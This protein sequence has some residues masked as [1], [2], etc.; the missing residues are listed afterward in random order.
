MY[1][2]RNMFFVL[3]HMHY[4]CSYSVAIMRKG[5]LSLRKSYS[6]WHLMDHSMLI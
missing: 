1:R 2:L 4:M 5:I 6:L 3:Q